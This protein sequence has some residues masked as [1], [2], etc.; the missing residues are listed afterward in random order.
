MI[1]KSLVLYIM[2]FSVFISSGEENGTSLLEAKLIEIEEVIE[3]AN[4]YTLDC[5]RASGWHFPSD[6]YYHIYRA[7]ACCTK[8]KG[9]MNKKTF[10]S[11]L[12]LQLSITQALEGQKGYCMGD[13]N[14][15]IDPVPPVPDCAQEIFEQLKKDV[16]ELISGE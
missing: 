11:L 8:K 15:W 10:Q 13:S 5:Q 14:V 3:E 12:H 9:K 6:L 1:Y 2:C 16:E 7:Q 4:I